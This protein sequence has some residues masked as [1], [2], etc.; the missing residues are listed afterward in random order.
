MAIFGYRDYAK[1]HAID[2]MISR[3]GDGEMIARLI[4]LFGGGTI[5]GSSSKGASTVLRLALKSLEN[6]R[7][8]GITPDGP[9][10]PRHS[11]ADGI[12]HLAQ[13]KHVPIV[14]INYNASA[15]WRMSSWDRF[16][17]PKPFCTLDFYYGEPFFVDGMNL[18]EAKSMIQKKL[19]EHAM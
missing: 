13:A 2:S 3:H 5:R 14:T 11:V 10:G 12:V 7:D 19:L 1:K 16:C 17:I 6:G 15:S 9:R 4:H 8:V 18:E